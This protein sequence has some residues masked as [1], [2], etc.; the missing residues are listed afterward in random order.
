M[1]GLLP[2]GQDHRG[3]QVCGVGLGTFGSRHQIGLRRDQSCLGLPDSLAVPPSPCWPYPL[4]RHP[5][6][7]FRECHTFPDR[8]LL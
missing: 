4:P 3:E 8:A 2:L 6:G 1:R 7:L 5:R